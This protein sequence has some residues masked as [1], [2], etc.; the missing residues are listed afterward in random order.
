[1]KQ[2]KYESV[3]GRL[4]KKMIL[5]VLATMIIVALI[6][7]TVSFHA[8]REETDG[9]Y[10]AITNV[11]SEKL[12]RILLH[13]EVCTRN[14]FDEIADNLDSPESVITALEKEIKL[15]NYI[16]GYFV[17]FEPGYFPQYPKWFEPYMNIYEEHVRNIGSADHDYLKH[18]WY[19]QAKKE[20]GGIWTGPYLDDVG[21][22]DNVCAFS[23]A[24]YD[25]K[26]RLAGVYGG[27][28]SLKWLVSQLQ[29]IDADSYHNGLLDFNLG[30]DYS[31]HTFII[32]RKG[33]Y[34]AHPEEERVLKDN[35]LRHIRDDDKS[36][37]QDM[38]QMKRGQATMTIDGVRSIVYYTPLAS[39]NW[40]MAIVVPQKAVWAGALTMIALLLLI[41]VIGL[42][43]IW[44]LCRSNIRQAISPLSELAK[45]ADE[46]AKG[47]FEAP[48]PE[49]QQKDEI[50]ELRDSFAS[51]QHSLVEYMKDLKEKTAK[52]AA[53]SRELHLANRL[54]MSM[55]PNQIP[56]FPER[57]DIDVYG[58]QKPA[59]MIGGDIFDYFIRD[60]KLFF[61]IGD[62]SG[63][64][65]PA[66]LVMTVIHY[67]FRIIAGREDEPKQIVELMNRYL[68]AE[69]KSSM[70][71]TYFLGVLD[72]KTHLLK[73]CN[74]G[75]ELPILITDNKV[76]MIDV[77]HNLA[78]GLMEKMVYKPGELQLSPGEV[79]LLCTD[80]IKEA[81][82]EAEE[83][84]EKERMIAALQ[85]VAD[86]RPAAEA[87]AYI[88]ALVD[89]VAEFEKN[90]PQAD[91]LTLLAIRIVE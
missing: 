58:M 34:I 15:N 61:S 56:P 16:Q 3:A 25:N 89:G 20:K 71:C 70:F 55:L 26:G 6:I 84:V 63:K 19:I 27:D 10:E 66:A 21:A 73:Y 47:N 14:A 40:S 75:H 32:N 46:V 7:L 30:K 57:T 78:L 41:I 17:G 42:V 79:F 43:I 67:L 52:E 69:N 23:M 65:I 35:V 74:A 28:M 24:L 29:D 51:M 13:E 54:Q 18:D 88:K 12:E 22:K 49:I 45:S 82:N 72:L 48:L 59:K 68:S 33:T 64:G 11:V 53:I 90:A 50:C 81:T 91:D 60:E 87:S 2:P 83:C 31:F 37:I 80:G 44:L 1:M 77:D 4:T 5:T 76:S 39:T 62:V 86:Q 36:V 9:R 38:M 8:I 85:Q